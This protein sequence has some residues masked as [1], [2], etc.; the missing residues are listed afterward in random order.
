MPPLPVNPTPRRLLAIDAAGA[1]LSAVSLGVVAPLWSNQLGTTPQVLHQ[2]A[3]LPLLYLLID[4]LALRSVLLPQ[5]AALC[6]VGLGNAL[7][8][9]AAGHL[10][11]HVGV[12]LTLWGWGYFGLECV[13]VCTLAVI[14]LR[15]AIRPQ[16]APTA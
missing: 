12:P 5:R 2:L 3:V 9:L 4:A 14:E 16:P 6:L 13:V 8:P 1:L 11:H 15:A 10:L 7:Y